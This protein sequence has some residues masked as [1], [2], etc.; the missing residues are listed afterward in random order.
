MKT[1]TINI[2]NDNRPII[3]DSKLYNSSMMEI[4]YKQSFDAIESILSAQK[5]PLEL[6]P[7]EGFDVE[8]PNNILVFDGERGSGKTS[9]ML[10]V[11]KMLIEESVEP[12]KKLQ[13]LSQTKFTMLPMLEPSFFDNERNVLNLI[14]SRLYNA[15]S[16]LTNIPSNKKREILSLF[17]EV[18]NKLKCMFGIKE[19]QDA[20]EYLVNLSAAI[21]LRKKL[22]KLIDEYLMVTDG[23]PSKLLILID[24]IDLNQNQA[25]M[26]V[27]EIRKYLIQDNCIVLI[28]VK[29]EQ[30]SGILY[31]IY[32]NEYKK[33][34][35]NDDIKIEIRN[36]VDRYISK[37]FPQRQRIFMPLPEVFLKYHI[38]VQAERIFDYQLVDDVT[39]EESIPELIFA[40]TRYL[41]YNTKKTAS[42]IVPRNLRSIRQILKL[43][44]E[45]P[46]YIN[47]NGSDVVNKEVFKHYFYN[48]WVE[49]NIHPI[50]KSFVEE[51]VSRGNL[52]SLNYV[53]V[54]YL[55]K[56]ITFNDS[57]S[58]TKE[59]VEI[60]DKVNQY[61][62]ISLGDVL[63]MLRMVE[64]LNFDSSTQKLLFFIKAFYSIK[65]YEAY[66][67]I[68]PD[69]GSEEEPRIKYYICRNE[70][71]IVDDDYQ[72]ILAGSVFNAPNT[73][74]LLG[75]M[76]IHP[77][78]FSNLFSAIGS[79]ADKVNRGKLYNLIEFLML[80]VSY[81]ESNNMGA[82]HRHFVDKYYSHFDLESDHAYVGSF[83]SFIYN[84][85][86]YRKAIYRFEAIEQFS[87]FFNYFED[88]KSNRLYNRLKDYAVNQRVGE[89]EKSDE[90]KMLSVCCFRNM[91]V[92]EDFYETI[93]ANLQNLTLSHSTLS[94]FFK[95]AKDYSIYTY[96]RYDP[97]GTKEP[98][99]I[100]F[101]YMSIFDE[102]FN[103]SYVQEKLESAFKVINHDP[104][105]TRD[106]QTITSENM[107]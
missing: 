50:H 26:M 7:I 60:I 35:D 77:N 70:K 28:S 23:S 25:S 101:S 30:L 13:L 69:M 54:H 94:L 58:N 14:V 12:Y 55:K 8:C 47:G 98:Y 39:V 41:F 44:M 83:G 105:A 34:S 45:M 103:D 1:L 100:N 64:N 43:L 2:D 84:L 10:S 66:D 42:Y 107:P 20:L 80:Y 49:Q 5:Y 68:T 89:K 27:E 19:K 9:C 86:S 40:K 32:E 57:V 106:T 99:K 92:L 36:R 33:T 21:D 63:S 53:V 81:R 72:A 97:D 87:S 16:K 4:Q 46:N 51:L 65:L 85:Y 82:V 88:P 93:V 11:A 75:K 18:Q 22:K 104:K 62:N 31:R 79:E 76:Q 52:E 3:E 78:V 24:D 56:Q 73:V 48:D 95:Y 71:G 74:S 38:K 29:I 102:F 15:F 91:E 61:Y 59:I 90:A 96:D 6:I 17:V 37:L 67:T